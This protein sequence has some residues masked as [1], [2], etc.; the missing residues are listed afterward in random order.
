LVEQPHVARL[1]A[2]GKRSRLAEL[3]N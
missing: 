3:L 1:C 2:M